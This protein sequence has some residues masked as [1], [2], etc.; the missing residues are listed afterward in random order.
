VGKGYRLPSADPAARVDWPAAFGTRFAVFVD[1]EEEFDWSSPFRRDA[2]GTGHMAAMPA[3]HARFAAA[4]VPLTFLV[5]HPIATCP[6]SVE[7]L[8]RLLEDGGSAIGTQL[9]PWVNP[10]FEEQ[11]N[12]ANSFAGNLPPALEAAKLRM[13]TDAIADAFGERPI[14]YRAGRYG[15]GPTT[16]ETLA[17]LGYRIDSSMRAGYDYSG[18]GGPDFSLVGNHGFRVGQLVELPLTTVFT[19]GARSGGARLYRALGRVP[20]GRG[21]AARLG[22]LSRIALT[23]EDMPLAEAQEAVRI[24]VG[25]G[26]R[27]L[28]FSFHSPSVEPGHTPY[29]RDAGDLAAF[30][31]WWE[32]M[33]ALLAR[34]G[35][36]PA[37]L[38]DIVEATCG[39]APSSATAAGAGG[40]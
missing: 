11:L 28:N 30:H 35:I 26:V 27:L 14:V 38:A 37:S 29:V 34:L 1:T 4:G 31:H 6:R 25:E 21:L 24:A 39:G 8:R 18:E 12:R 17:A 9:H 2:R 20:R 3:T 10:P 40:L 32:A 5:D 36:A 23:P 7:V 13:L 16:F 15:I 19:G 22:L 33:L